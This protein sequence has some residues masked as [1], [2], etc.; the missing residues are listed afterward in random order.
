MKTCNQ[1]WHDA[2][3]KNYEDCSQC[4]VRDNGPWP[5]NPLLQASLKI[6]KKWWQFWKK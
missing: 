3:G 4:F 1:N 2:F 6:E 5:D